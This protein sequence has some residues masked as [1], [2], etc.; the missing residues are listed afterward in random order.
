MIPFAAVVLLSAFFSIIAGILLYGRSPSHPINRILMVFAW[1]L[2]FWGFTEFECLQ[3]NDVHQALFWMRLNASWYLVPAVALH[4]SILYS[5]LRVNRP[6]LYSSVYAPPII[7]ALYEILATP[8]QPVMT[9]WGWDYYYTGSFGYVELLWG[10]LA[11]VAALFIIMGRYR[12]AKSPEQKTGVVYVFSGFLIPMVAGISYG[13]L[14]LFSIDVPDLTMPTSA[15]GFFLV[16]YAVWRHGTYVLTASTATEDILSTMP[17]ALFLVNSR[18]EIN[19]SNRTASTLFEYRT[20][21]LVGKMLTS[22]SQ[23]PGIMEAQLR[24]STS[25]SFEIGF[26]TKRGLVIPVSVSKSRILTKG[27]NLLGWILI[28]RDI[29]E[30]KRLEQRLL[31]AERMGTIGETTSMVGHD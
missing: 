6:I 20:S 8:Y 18:G 11:S 13:V 24:D 3:A 23:D 12:N 28:C 7:L 5:N 19:V 30:R 22:L 16:G 9:P 26:K 14:L 29:T 27:G 21:E 25:T 15:L 1:I 4:I 17:D 10:V 2:F 31:N